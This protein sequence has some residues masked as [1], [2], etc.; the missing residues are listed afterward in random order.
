MALLL[1]GGDVSFNGDAAVVVGAAARQKQ[2]VYVRL[3]R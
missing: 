1:A 2:N 3:C